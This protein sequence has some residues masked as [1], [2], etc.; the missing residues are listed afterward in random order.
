MAIKS[1]V[2]GRDQLKYRVR[3]AFVNE[4][5]KR[6]IEAKEKLQAI[7]NA[8]LLEDYDTAKRLAKDAININ[9]TKGSGKW[10]TKRK[11]SAG[12]GS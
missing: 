8:V 10:I 6:V 7:A 5:D 4:Y 11:L 12:N 3:R 9:N 2:K 1:T